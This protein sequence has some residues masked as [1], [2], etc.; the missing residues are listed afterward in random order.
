MERVLYSVISFIL[1]QTLICCS[2]DDTEGYRYRIPEAAY[3]GWSTGDADENGLSS[4]TLSDMMAYIN[5]T[6]LG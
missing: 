3:D 1:L 2:G 6:G 4:E 5:R